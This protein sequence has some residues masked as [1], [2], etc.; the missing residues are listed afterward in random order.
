[1]CRSWLKS[2]LENQM[3]FSTPLKNPTTSLS[4]KSI[5]MALI[6]GTTA[7]ISPVHAEQIA[8]PHEIAAMLN[9]G[10]YVIYVRHTSTEKDYADQLTADVNNCSTQRTLSEKGWD[11]ATLIGS[12]FE[13]LKIPVGS[14]YSSE[15]CRAWKTARLA[16]GAPVKLS[17]LNFEKSEEYTDAQMAIMRDNVDPLLKQAPLAGTNTIIVGHDDPFE[18]ATGIYPE[19]QGVAYVVKPGA[20]DKFEIVGSIKPTDWP[21][22]LSA[23]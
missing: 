16:F 22:I 9:K 15:Y 19:P 10:G 11:E 5:A 3:K 23:Q 6:L 13:I 14:I 17:K 4:C 1:M 18:A 12:S 8:K 2:K 21:D 20:D 7:A